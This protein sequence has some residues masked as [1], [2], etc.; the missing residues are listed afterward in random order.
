MRRL[1]AFVA[2][3][4]F[5]P[6]ANAQDKGKAEFSPSAEFR[7]RYN[8]AQNGDGTERNDSNVQD[9]MKFGANYKANEKLSAHATVLHAATIGQDVNTVAVGN[10]NTN[11]ADNVLMV[12]EAYA[13]WMFS[14]DLS[15]KFGRQTYQIADGSLIAVNDWE[16][17]PTA[18]EGL[19]GNW[20]AE[21]GRFQ[22]IAFKQ[23][24]LGRSSAAKDGEHNL[25]GLNFDLK[26]MPNWL[27]AVNVH[28]LK[29]NADALPGATATDINSATTTNGLDVVRYGAMASFNFQMI[30]LKLNYEATTGKIKTVAGTATPFA[31]GAV[32]ESDSK[33]TMMQAEVGAKFD[34]FMGSRVFVV[35]HQDSGAKSKA[36][37]AYDNFFYEKHDNAGL[38]DLVDWGN[39]TYLTVGLTLKPGDNTDAGIMW[40]NFSRTE[41]GNTSTGDHN[42]FADA[43]YG[44]VSK[45]AIGNEIDVWGEHRYDGGLS[46]V[47][48]VGYF[49]AGDYLKNHT[50]KTDENIL[51]V[52]VEGKLTF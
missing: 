24:E 50:P 25:Y 22:L 28:V 4:S 9:R 26:T 20:E 47:L 37:D 17:N 3:V 42:V 10:T 30:D 1:L 34:G 43:G 38:M 49:T 44:D 46:T 35:Y 45:D 52:M 48:R 51:Q 7:A 6:T 39:L 36:G 41:K 27:K 32:T 12:N 5:L 33:G 21:F 11:A 16:Q 18:F 23:R 40:H 29:D 19:V 2:L 13:N 14:D 31:P 15:F 8:W